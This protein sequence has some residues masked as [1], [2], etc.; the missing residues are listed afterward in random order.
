MRIACYLRVSTDNQTTDNQVPDIEQEL[1]KYPGADVVYFKENESAAKAGHQKALAQLK[2]LIRSGRTKFDILLIWAFD[3][4]TRQG[5]IDLIREYNFF[6][7]YGVKVISI[8]E[9]WLDVPQ[10]FL[11][12]LLSLIGYLAQMESKRRSERTKAGLERVRKYGSKT[13]RGI[14]KRGPDKTKRK[15]SGYLNRW[16][17]KGAENIEAIS[18][19]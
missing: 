1:L 10:E 12:V 16:I 7:K 13:G 15:R 9:P 8:K 3:R 14:G 11:P 17:N 4:L 2:A 18:N 6:I 5:S 19:T